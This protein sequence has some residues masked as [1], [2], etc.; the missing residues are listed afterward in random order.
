[1]FTYIENPK[2]QSRPTLRPDYVLKKNGMIIAILD[3]KYRDL[4]ENDLPP[5]MLYQLVMYALSQE[6]CNQSTILYPAIE[7]DAQE[8][9]IEVR[10]PTHALGRVY[11]VLR[12]VDLLK[13]EEIINNSRNKGH[14]E[15]E[16][17]RA[18][19]ARWLVFGGERE[20]AP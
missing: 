16:R 11:V 5:H 2:R 15:I 10:L 20:A 13:L 19:F 3:A 14:S 9:E 4:W 6:S 12:P 8:E 1:M 17:E 7:S 18:K